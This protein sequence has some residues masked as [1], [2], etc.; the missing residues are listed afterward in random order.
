MSMAFALTVGGVT[1]LLAVIW[2]SPLVEIMRRLRLGK[3]IRIEGPRSHL[4]KMGTPAMGGLLIIGWVLIVSIMVNL[5][6]DEETELRKAIRED[7][8]QD[9][10]QGDAPPWDEDEDAEQAR[11]RRELNDI[12]RGARLL[13]KKVAASEAVPEALKQRVE[14]TLVELE[15]LV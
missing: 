6:E 15:G 12:L 7:M 1:F 8:K 3:Q 5:V 13:R 14:E 9:G 10:G 11:R 2:G 4:A